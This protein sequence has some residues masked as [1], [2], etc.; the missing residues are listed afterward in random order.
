MGPGRMPGVEDSGSREFLESMLWVGWSVS[1][2]TWLRLLSP[3]SPETASAA[4][5]ERV[6]D[7]CGPE[8]L[9]VG[10]GGGRQSLS[11]GSL[12]PA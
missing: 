4:A 7:T 3:V 6:Q 10:A 12:L 5:R 11:A 1:K 9:R 8:Y 2:G